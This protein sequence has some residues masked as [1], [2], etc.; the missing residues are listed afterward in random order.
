MFFL[1]VPMVTDSLRF[2]QSYAQQ[3]GE[4]KLVFLK[5]GAADILVDAVRK[6]GVQVLN[7]LLQAGRTFAVV[8]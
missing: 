5:Q 2:L 4:E 3:E 1:H 6:V 7:S 8:D